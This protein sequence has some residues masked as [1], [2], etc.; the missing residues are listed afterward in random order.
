VLN[1]VAVLLPPF[2]V[3]WILPV[4]SNC[5]DSYHAGEYPKQDMD[6]KSLQIAPAATRAVKMM[7]LRVIPRVVDRFGQFLP[8]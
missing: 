1:P 3:A 7:S 5:R 4:V 2:S 6:R 8:E